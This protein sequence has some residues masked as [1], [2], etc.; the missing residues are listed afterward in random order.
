MLRIYIIQFFFCVAPKCLLHIT[1]FFLANYIGL[2]GNAHNFFHLEQL[3]KANLSSSEL[4]SFVPDKFEFKWQSECDVYAE[5][6]NSSE[7][8]IQELKRVCVKNEQEAAIKALKC[9]GKSG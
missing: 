8:N 6:V 7:L 2:T 1:R 4:E 9:T 3:I 5:E